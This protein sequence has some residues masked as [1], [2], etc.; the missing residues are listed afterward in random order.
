MIHDVFNDIERGV[1]CSLF[2]G[3]LWRRER[4]VEFIVKK[5][6]EAVGKVEKWS[7]KWGFKGVSEEV[8]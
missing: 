4:N 2:D 8:K 7:Y 3:A 5:P 6:Q 1:G